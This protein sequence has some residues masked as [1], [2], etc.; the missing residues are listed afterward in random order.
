MTVLFLYTQAMGFIPHRGEHN[1]TSTLMESQKVINKSTIEGNTCFHIRRNT[2][3]LALRRSLPLLLDRPT[4]SSR[5]AGNRLFFFCAF[6]GA[7]VI[8]FSPNTSPFRT[9]PFAV[10]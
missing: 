4:S 2:L 1:A 9:E 10:P 5:S 7:K 8:S 3:P 6:A